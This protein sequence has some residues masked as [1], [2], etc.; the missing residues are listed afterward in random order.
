MNAWWPFLVAVVL[1]GGC[2]VAVLEL[3]RRRHAREHA[4]DYVDRIQ[5]LKTDR[6]MALPAVRERKGVKV[7]Q[8]K[9]RRARKA[10]ATTEP[11][12]RVK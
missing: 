3:L 5:A 4:A 1:P 8:V 12:R 9:S 6:P 7:A 10:K 11:L 2:I